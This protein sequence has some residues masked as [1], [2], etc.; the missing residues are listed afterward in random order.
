MGGRSPI[1][2]HTFESLAQ[3]GVGRLP[4]SLFQPPSPKSNDHSFGNNL[5]TYKELCLLHRQI[6]LCILSQN[7]CNPPFRKSVTPPS[8]SLKLNPYIQL[9]F[10]ILLEVWADCEG[11]VP[12]NINHKY[13]ENNKFKEIFLKIKGHFHSIY[14]V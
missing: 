3:L 1:P 2:S 4:L 5:T 11:W 14:N 7:L 12:T 9:L 13:K 6:K 10:L 8:E